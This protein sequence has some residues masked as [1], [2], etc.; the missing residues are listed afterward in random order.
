VSRKTEAVEEVREV[1]RPVRIGRTQ[2]VLQP[3]WRRREPRETRGLKRG[4]GTQ[5]W[6]WEEDSW[7]NS[8]ESRMACDSMFLSMKVCGNRDFTRVVRG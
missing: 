7:K 2:D 3:E 5:S 1:I 6:G 8:W 4:E